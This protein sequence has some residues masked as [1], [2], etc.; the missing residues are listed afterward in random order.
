MFIP[1]EEA[2][3][4]AQASPMWVFAAAVWF[5]LIL[6]FFLGECLPAKV[7]KEP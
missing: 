1:T 7:S 5:V 4:A 3:Q 2:F 6:A